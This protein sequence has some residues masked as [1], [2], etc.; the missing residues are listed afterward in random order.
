MAVFYLVRLF[1]VNLLD[2]NIVITFK[3]LA[4]YESVCTIFI[5][6]DFSCCIIVHFLPN[7]AYIVLQMLYKNTELW[8]SRLIMSSFL[9]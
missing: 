8:P 5:F 9:I 1:F 3:E 2:G 4:F 6:P 7:F